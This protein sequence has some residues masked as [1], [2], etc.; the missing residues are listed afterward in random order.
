MSIDDWD[1]EI[2]IMKVREMQF[3]HLVKVKFSS[4]PPS[5]MIS[6][7]IVIN[8]IYCTVRKS[9]TTMTKSDFSIDGHSAAAMRYGKTTKKTIVCDWRLN[10]LPICPFGGVL[11]SL[12]W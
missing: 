2:T 4:V 9:S 8:V 6:H 1:S 10:E 5:Q 7:R 11:W 3:S 12:D